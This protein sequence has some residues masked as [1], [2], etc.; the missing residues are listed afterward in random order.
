M[1]DEGDEAFKARIAEL[2]RHAFKEQDDPMLK[3]QQENIR[4]HPEVK[5]VLL[6]ID[7]GPVRCQRL[8]DSMIAAEQRT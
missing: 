2:R 3:A 6:E 8:L 7:A 5:P 4:R 1:A